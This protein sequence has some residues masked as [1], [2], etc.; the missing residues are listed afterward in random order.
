M[1]FLGKARKED[2]LWLISELDLEIPENATIAKLRQ[3]ILDQKIFEEF[4]RNSV[5]TIVAERIEKLERG[6]LL[7]E[8]EKEQKD[9]EFELEKLRLERSPN[10]NLEKK[11]H[12]GIW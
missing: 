7:L 8:Q 2:L 12:C 10:K 11:K 6:K 5:D 4:T 3:V 1:L 9:R